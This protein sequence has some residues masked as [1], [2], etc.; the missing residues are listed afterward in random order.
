MP[1]WTAGNLGKCLCLSELP[2]PWLPS[3]ENKGNVQGI[4]EALSQ[5][6]HRLPQLLEEIS[7][8]RPCPASLEHVGG[9]PAAWDYPS[10][11]PE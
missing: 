3:M 2:F 7:C 1:A 9:G 8:G 11:T 5:C 6:R 4:Q 10:F